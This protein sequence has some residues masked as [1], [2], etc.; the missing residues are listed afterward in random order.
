MNAE[1]ILKETNEDTRA[2]RSIMAIFVKHWVKLSAGAQAYLRV[3]IMEI[4]NEE[5][6]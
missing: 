1:E 5:A 2:M 4:L 6:K 3:K